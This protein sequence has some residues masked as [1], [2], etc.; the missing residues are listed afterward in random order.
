MDGITPPDLKYSQMTSSSLTQISDTQAHLWYVFPERV[1]DDTLLKSC[2]ELL[3]D[4][5]RAQQ[6]R[7]VFEK[8]RHLYLVAHA[9]VRTCL[10]RYMDVKPEHWVFKKNQYGKPFIDYPDAGHPIQFS[11][12][13]TKGFVACLVT[14]HHNVGVDV[15]HMAFNDRKLDIARSYFSQDEV[16]NLLS[17]PVDRQHIR[18]YEYWTLKE[19]YIKAKGAGLSIPLD[20]FSFQLDEGKGIKISFIQDLYDNP[21][22]WH[23]CLYRLT[24]NHMCAVAVESE[25][26]IEICC[27]DASLPI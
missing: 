23:F 26:P 17:S 20:K 16:Q 7:F 14:S 12:S 15:E 3:S 27:F 9:L 5:E 6:Q 21:S 25:K 1:T 2:F 10:S 8:D 13:H 18:F 11:L 24:P 4:E 22:Q 19:A